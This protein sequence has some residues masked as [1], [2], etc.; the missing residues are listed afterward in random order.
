MQ[1]HALRQILSEETHARQPL[2]AACPRMV[3]VLIIPIHSQEEPSLHQALLALLEQRS[4]PMP[5]AD[6][7]QY[8]AESPDFSLSYSYHTEYVRFI[9]SIPIDHDT[10]IASPFLETPLDLLPAGWLDNVAAD[11]LVAMHIAIVEELAEPWPVKAISQ[12]FFDGQQLIGGEIA[13][14]N[15]RALSDFRLHHDRHIDQG[16]SRCLV[17]DRSMGAAQAG[18][19]VQRL[20]EMESY[21]LLALWALPLAKQQ[22]GVVDDLG[23]R[24]CDL[25]ARIDHPEENDAGLLD[26]LSR[27]S[28]EAERMISES[29]YRYTASLAYHS[30]VEHRVQEL[31]ELRIPGTQPFGEFIERRLVPAINTCRM[32]TQRQDRL[33][34]R[35][36]RASTLLRTRVEVTHEQQNQHLLASVNQR[37]ALQ[38]KL[39]ETVEGLSVVVLTYYSLSLCAYALKALKSLGVTWL[40]V[41][42]ATG[43]LIIPVAIFIA[44]GKHWWMKKHMPHSE[45]HCAKD[46]LDL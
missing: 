16:A 19:M 35:L 30:V 46:A 7:T 26:D 42:L 11:I 6:T 33:M 18:R 31:R 25:I 39:Q 44:V 29:E 38:S 8:T 17:I 21:R 1:S 28:L 15:G 4:W 5:L 12:R 36:Q 13:K 37:V 10:F 27:L 34:R 22:M 43:L 9:F 14:G 2:A 3:S 40:N 23:E 41:E 24:L 20:I 45:V 32:L